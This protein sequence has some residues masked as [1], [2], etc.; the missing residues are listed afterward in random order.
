[1]ADLLYADAMQQLEVALL[2]SPT[3]PVLDLLSSGMQTTLMPVMTVPLQPSPKAYTSTPP[4]PA[5]TS[6]PVVG[7]S[8]SLPSVVPTTASS[9]KNVEPAVPAKTSNVIPQQHITPVP[10]ELSSLTSTSSSS[11]PTSI[12]TL[13]IIIM[14]ELVIPAETYPKWINRPGGGKDY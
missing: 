8:S 6:V 3:A 2:G 4:A 1:M 9:S 11:V 10:V 7:I 12:T 14:P 5:P 13:P